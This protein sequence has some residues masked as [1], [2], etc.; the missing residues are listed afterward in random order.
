M[1]T[2]AKNSASTWLICEK[3]VRSIEENTKNTTRES[4]KCFDIIFVILD[5]DEKTDWLWNLYNIDWTTNSQQL[6]ETR[7]D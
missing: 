3:I 1:S 5:V 7:D 4:N 6:K 2:T